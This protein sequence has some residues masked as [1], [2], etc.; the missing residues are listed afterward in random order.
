MDISKRTSLVE[1]MTVKG[2][3]QYLYAV[4]NA[5]SLIGRLVWSLIVLWQNIF[6]SFQ[7]IFIFFLLE[8]KLLK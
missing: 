4:L 1:K 8:A 2:L 3:I 5:I 6:S 7:F